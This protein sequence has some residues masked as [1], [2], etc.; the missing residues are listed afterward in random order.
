[1][2][3][4][5]EDF[6][7]QLGRYLARVGYTQQEFAHK[8]RMHRNTVVKWMNRTAR[9]SSRSQ[10]LRLA[11]ELSLTKQE[12]RG[13]LQAA[14]FS[15]DRWPTEVW[16]VPQQQDMFFTGRDEMFRS[17]RDMLIP[18]STTALTQAISG[19]GGI[20]KTH[21]AVE[22]AYRFHQDYEAVLWLQADSW[23]TLVSACIRLA[24]ELELP[25]QKEADQIVAEV[26]YWLRKHRLWLL[27]LD[28]VENPQE[29]LS[30]FVPTQ[31][32]G[33]IL[34]TTRVRDIEPLAQTQ[35]LSMLPEDEGILFLLRRTRKITLNAG[36]DQASIAQ[37]EDARQIWQLMDGLP[38]ALDQAGAYILE[39][40]CSFSTYRE[41]YARR[42]AELLD[43]RGKRFIGHE[44]SVATTFSLAFERIEVLN[45]VAADILR[46][47]S[48]LS[49]EAI[50]EEIFLKGAQHLGPLLAS[51]GEQWDLVVG[52]L[53][54]Y[55]LV[56][57]NSE[58]KTL[59]IHRLVQAVL[60]DAMEASIWQLWAN[61]VVQA[62]ETVVAEV[63]YH[64]AGGFERFL[65]HAQSCFG[66]IKQCHLT[67][68][69]AT[70][71]LYRTGAYLAE[72]AQYTEAEALYIQ[73]LLIREKTLG[74]DHPDAAYPLYALAE[75]YRNQGRYGAAA[76]LYQQTLRIWRLSLGP[77]HSEVAYP[78]SG[79]AELYHMQGKYSEAEPLYVQALRIVE[80]AFGP[81]HPQVVALQNHLAGLYRDQGKYGEA[82]A[83]Y[84]QTLHFEVQRIDAEH[85]SEIAA[86][87]GLAE[88]YR[89]QG[90]YREAEAVYLRVLHAFEQVLDSEHPA[91]APLLHNLANLYLLQN[92]HA[93]AEVLY[94]RSLHILERA[95]G[96][97]HHQLAHSLNSLSNISFLQSNYA[98]AESLCRR[99][100]HIYEQVL[101]P[102]NAQL[103]SPLNNLGKIYQVQGKYAEAESLCQQALS[104]REQALGPEHREVAT[105]LS[106]LA[107]LYRKQ[108]RYSEA[109]SFYQRAIFVREQAL[110]PEHPELPTPLK[111]LANLY[112]EQGKFA[113]A[114]PLYQRAIHI[115]EQLL[116]LEH[117][118]LAPLLTNLA[119]LDQKQGNDAQAES[120][121]QRALHIQE[122]AAGLEHPDVAIQLDKLANLYAKQEKYEK[123]E[124]LYQRAIDIWKQAKGETHVNMAAPL[125]N[126]AELYR[127]QRRYE[128]AEPLFQ[129]AIS[130]WE[131]EVGPEHPHMAQGLNNLALI[132]GLQGKYKEAELLHQ[133]A[134]HIREQAFGLEHI[135]VA[136]SRAHL[137]ILYSTQGKYTEA[138]LLLMHALPVIAQKFG[139]HH[140][141]TIVLQQLYEFLKQERGLKQR[142][143]R[144]KRGGQRKKQKQR[145]TQLLSLEQEHTIQYN[146]VHKRLGNL[147][148]RAP[149]DIKEMCSLMLQAW[150]EV[151]LEESKTGEAF[152]LY[153]F[154]PKKISQ[155]VSEN[156][157]HEGRNPRLWTSEGSKQVKGNFYIIDVDQSPFEV[158]LD[159]DFYSAPIPLNT[160][161]QQAFIVTQQ[162]FFAKNGQMKQQHNPECRRIYEGIISATQAIHM[163]EEIE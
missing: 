145:R 81:G 96:P 117:P 31:H 140:S 72:H 36:L 35:V 135:E 159:D 80:Q 104:I 71:L 157:I 77:E 108:K 155:L 113:E 67:S 124:P 47:C 134:L 160:A 60:K 151:I 125:N 95:F 40:G 128:E 79:L 19:L 15:L 82:E 101:E 42:R 132:Y 55:S 11:D 17:L 87:Q 90:R 102:T 69:S 52:V 143:S 111:G 6:A 29:I 91:I 130:I 38:L 1:M 84:Q 119:D 83:L 3:E 152:A 89:Y 25:E 88:L 163:K 32:Q 14:G 24:A 116:G 66:L 147:V 107:E 153:G 136:Q 154:P 4:Y 48:L 26:Q 115:Q 53:Q 100:L 149:E 16:T 146:L 51:R 129:W 63:D 122:Q 30:R 162:R 2:E 78:L 150:E 110:G 68:R 112:S 22:Y 103:A 137:A 105:S 75:L 27:I 33:S 20:G 120:L 118:E 23:E 57:R 121:Y 148:D 34:I 54:D 144:K 85:L 74:S 131:S 156:R 133:R 161:L 12:R 86:L 8:I 28:N 64:P 9:P 58:A 39:T 127:E 92:K 138:E 73:C 158:A 126:L 142:Q 7:D 98:E 99:A 93:E 139:P 43:R 37:Q 41:Q 109:E 10:V 50:P 123:A 18:G 97:D 65:A 114:G 62:V 45:P 141:Q 59:T 21:T 106:T 94:R 61:R 56:Q 13:F 44:E 49:S 46:A 70:Q 76:P 5:R